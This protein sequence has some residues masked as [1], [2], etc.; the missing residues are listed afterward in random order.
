MSYTGRGLDPKPTPP[1]SWNFNFR[2]S[3]KSTRFPIPL[4]QLPSSL[5]AQRKGFNPRLIATPHPHPH[6]RPRP[7]LGLARAC[8]ARPLSASLAVP[9]A[10]VLGFRREVEE[11]M[12]PPRPQGSRPWPDL[13]PESQPE[14]VRPSVASP[15]SPQ[16]CP[17]LS[18]SFRELPAPVPVRL[19]RRRPEPFCT[20][21]ERKWGRAGD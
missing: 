8:P 17:S 3:P 7:G 15:S 21:L 6:P 2:G 13:D 12:P 5:Q 11:E 10:P 19:P 4:P 20:L 1:S 18:R 14:W 16:P 9:E